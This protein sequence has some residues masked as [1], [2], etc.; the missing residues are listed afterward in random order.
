MGELSEALQFTF[1]LINSSKKYLTAETFGF[2]IAAS[3]SSLKKK[4]TW[5]LEQQTDGSSVYFKSFLGRY[6]GA[7]KN[8]NVSCDAE[9][10]GDENAFQVEATTDGR[11]AIKSSKYGRY[12]GGSGDNLSCF[13][14]SVSP[15]YLWMVHLAMHPQV[16]IYNIRRKCYANNTD[17][18]VHMTKRTPWGVDT[19][20]T[21]V[22]KDK[23]YALVT[24]NNMYLASDGSLEKTCSDKTLFTIEFYAG[25]I[26]FKSK[27]DSKYLSPNG[28]KGAL[29]GRKDTPG[30]DEHF[31]L[32]DSHPQI[33]LFSKTKKKFVSGKQGLQLSANQWEAE[34]NETFQ[35]EMD[36]K[37][38]SVYLH[39]DK[40]K[41]WRLNGQSISADVSENKSPETQ[42]EI[43]WHGR[44]IRL[45][46]SNGKYVSV[47]PSGHL[48]VSDEAE[49]FVFRLTNRPLIV[50]RGE[51]GF[52]GCKGEKLEGNRASYDI[53]HMEENEGAYA[54]KAPSGKYWA[55]DGDK[56]VAAN[57]AEPQYFVIELVKGSKIAL[58]S[59]SGG[60]YITSDHVG[61]MKADG[62]AINKS[63][64][65][66]Y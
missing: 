24:S 53:F 34:E 2:K 11:W 8:G 33:T 48:A 43:E 17:D 32:V 56:K 54:L 3:G 45:K 1:G 7:D 64:L 25:K 12:F 26:A 19:L 21:L 28:P 44:F 55:I 62:S 59:E 13:E 39:N 23:G 9:T 57:S 15:A 35:M 60:G 36:A 51:N 22:F 37:S 20:I 61:I 30:K 4:Q 41:Y 5:S 16:N 58:K 46:A 52:I 50:F 18:A 29:H 42:F 6:L 31:T 38:N 63:T 66:E 27:S 40:D 49:D 65:W 10:P 47:L 14:Q